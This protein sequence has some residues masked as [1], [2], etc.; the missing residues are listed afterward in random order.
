MKRIDLGQT[1]QI[2]ANVGVIIGLIFLI[3]DM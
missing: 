3:L 2:L 1:F